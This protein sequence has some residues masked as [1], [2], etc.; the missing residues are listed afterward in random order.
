[1]LKKILLCT[2]CALLVCTAAWGQSIHS[3][4]S[5]NENITKTIVREWQPQKIITYIETDH[6]HYFACGTSS[7]TLTLGDFD[8]TFTINDF[9]IANDY[10]YF[11]GKDDWDRHFFGW[12]K[13][14][15]FFFNNGQYYVHRQ[16]QSPIHPFDHLAV[17]ENNNK[18]NIV[19]IGY[20]N[21][22]SFATAISGVAGDP[23]SWSHTFGRSSRFRE[24]MYD[25]VVTDK[26]FVIGGTLYDSE[27]GVAL[28][29]IDK[30]L[31]FS[32]APIYDKAYIYAKQYPAPSASLSHIELASL[33]GD[34]VAATV[35]WKHQP[36]PST[37]VDGSMVQLYDINDLL[38]NINVF[39]ISTTLSRHNETLSNKLI[40]D[41]KYD[42]TSNLLYLLENISINNSTQNIV[43]QW[44]PLGS[45]TIPYFLNNL[46]QQSLDIY[47]GGGSLVSVGPDSANPTT[48][49]FFFQPTSS[50]TPC[51]SADSLT[52]EEP[53]KWQSKQENTPLEL[54]NAPLGFA[55][56]QSTITTLSTNI[57]CH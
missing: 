34:I 41:L 37:I 32:G 43:S 25:V 8:S 33:P 31:L 20:Y 30:F 7:G 18:V 42:A 46:T 57:N 53:H 10:V 50:N 47:N 36:L 38:T 55:S 21:N 35:V 3:K 2:I 56:Y 17:Y 15:D 48:L 45:T 4:L 29:M 19:A 13:I 16:G 27:G 5:L 52:T 14:Q 39:P 22:E 6:N 11:C 40:V 9:E 28:R 1:M 26:Y 23:L 51:G 24:H 54:Y 12:F 44:N 49:N